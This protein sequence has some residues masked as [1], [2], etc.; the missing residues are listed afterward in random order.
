MP[1]HPRPDQTGKRSNTGQFFIG[2]ILIQYVG[3][4]WGL[5][6]FIGR[7]GPVWAGGLPNLILPAVTLGSVL[8]GPIARLTRTAVLE[9]LGADYV[10]TERAKGC[11][12][13]PSSC[14]THYAMRSSRWS[15]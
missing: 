7:G 9:V 2:L 6:P 8:I 3:F 5:L 10:R 15:R 4:K 1:V 14:V 12:R 11:V 13:L